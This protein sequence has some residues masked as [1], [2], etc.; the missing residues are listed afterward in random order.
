MDW[1]ALAAIFCI[2]GIPMSIPIIKILTKHQREMLE[3]RIRLQQGDGVVRGEIQE[4]RREIQALRETSMQYDLSFDAA[5]QRLEQRVAR[6]E[7]N[8]TIRPT[9]QNGYGNGYGNSYENN[10]ADGVINTHSGN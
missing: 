6:T 3:M 9:Y 5:L 1:V 2:F 4:L 7:Q 8:T 10:E